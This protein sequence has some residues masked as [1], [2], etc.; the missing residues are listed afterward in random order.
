MT[1]VKGQRTGRSRYSCGTRSAATGWETTSISTCTSAPRR[2]GTGGSTRPTKS[3]LTV[4]QQAVVFLL[5][6]MG[7]QSWI[8]N[9][10]SLIHA[11]CVS[12]SCNRFSIISFSRS[13]SQVYTEM[14]FSGRYSESRCSAY[15][16]FFPRHCQEAGILFMSHS[17]FG[18]FQPRCAD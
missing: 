2:V 7:W 3:P 6:Y 16:F 12:I 17:V 10:R 1:K 13:V 4:R 5:F 9:K 8:E 14:I 18:L 15:F 11:W